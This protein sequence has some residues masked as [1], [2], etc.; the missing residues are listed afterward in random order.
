M[1]DGVLSLT[2]HYVLSRLV[3]EIASL[4]PGMSPSQVRQILQSP[5]VELADDLFQYENG[6]LVD[7]ILLEVCRSQAPGA[8][9]LVWVALVSAD[10]R[11]RTCS[12]SS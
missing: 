3:T 2:K 4:R 7:S 11:L 6:Q 9:R 12:P 10:W 1:A 8:V 5:H